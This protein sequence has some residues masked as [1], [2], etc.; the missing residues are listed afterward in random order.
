MIATQLITTGQVITLD[1]ALGTVAVN[2]G[3]ANPTAPR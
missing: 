2:V 3:T 1:G